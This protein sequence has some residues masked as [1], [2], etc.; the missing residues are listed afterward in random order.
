MYMK[1][2]S[3]SATRKL[4][5]RNACDRKETQKKIGRKHGRHTGVWEGK[6]Q[7][8][9]NRAEGRLTDIRAWS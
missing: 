3:G 9:A 2:H 1:R 8:R 6:E 4:G 5:K 7:R